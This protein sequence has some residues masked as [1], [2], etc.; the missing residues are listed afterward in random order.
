VSE[1]GHGSTGD[2]RPGPAEDQVGL[3][4]VRI[5]LWNHCG[6]ADPLPG[7]AA[8]PP[9]GER[10]AEASKAGRGAIEVIDEIIATCMHF[11]ARSSP[12]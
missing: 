7:Q 2:W 6:Y 9:L 12:S 1:T 3:L 11:A 8:M 5:A 10:K 4:W